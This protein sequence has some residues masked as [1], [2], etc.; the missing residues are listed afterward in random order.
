MA[1]VSRQVPE[2]PREGTPP[3]TK[4]AV[5]PRALGKSPSFSLRPALLPWVQTELLKVCTR[6]WKLKPKL[7]GYRAKSGDPRKPRNYRK[8]T[9]VEK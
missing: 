1:A 6:A 7:S 3:L 5:V 9:K 4:G 2:T 8:V